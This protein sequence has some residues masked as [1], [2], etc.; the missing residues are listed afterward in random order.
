MVERLRTLLERPLDPSV[1]RA[2]LVLA[3]AASIGFAAVALLAGIG[4]RPP[5]VA[6]AGHGSSL[7]RA[8]AGDPRVVAPPS[9]AEVAGQD[10]Q[11]RPGTAAHRRAL[12][13]VAS[14][15]ALQHLPYRA[16]GVSIMLVGARRGRALLRVEAPTVGAARRGWRDFLRRFRDQGSAYVPRFE[17]GGGGHG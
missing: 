14:H 7:H 9:S 11:D 6:D 12:G 13:E 2:M 16:G 4:D 15:R 3:L 10:R 5:P 1:A 8:G 17:A